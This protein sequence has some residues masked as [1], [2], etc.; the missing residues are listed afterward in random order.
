M[1]KCFNPTLCQTCHSPGRYFVL[2]SPLAAMRAA[3]CC[4]SI[5]FDCTR[6]GL[7][8]IFRLIKVF[9]SSFYL[10]SSIFF[11]SL[12]FSVCLISVCNTFS[13]NTLWFFVFW[14]QCLRVLFWN[15]FF[16][17]KTF[18]ILWCRFIFS[19]QVMLTWT[20]IVIT[21]M[22]LKLLRG[23]KLIGD[24]DS[25]RCARKEISFQNIL[26]TFPDPV[27]ELNDGLPITGGGDR[28]EDFG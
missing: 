8:G 2:Q 26:K 10:A 13:S 21:Q 7:K 11:F 22:S 9:R 24:S 1:R 18:S 27:S 15:S 14:C 4:C 20:Q 25:I 19:T 16:L 17:L 3:T 5:L 12:F 28:I 6:K 23:N